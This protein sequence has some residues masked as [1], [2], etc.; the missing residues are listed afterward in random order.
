LKF[1]TSGAIFGEPRV[2]ACA[3]RLPETGGNGRIFGVVQNW[4]VL[5]NKDDRI[6][7]LG[8]GGFG[9]EM[10]KPGRVSS[11]SGVQLKGV[12]TA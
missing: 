9:A 12:E 5:G 4:P 6:L 10:N 11:R 7:P 1:P 3:G 2:S 8:E